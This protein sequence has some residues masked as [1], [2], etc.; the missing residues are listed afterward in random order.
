[1]VWADDVVSV[2]YQRQIL[3]D[4]FFEGRETSLHLNKPFTVIVYSVSQTKKG[5]NVESVYE[6][7]LFFSFCDVAFFSFKK[8]K[9]LQPNLFHAFIGRI[10]WL[11]LFGIRI[12]MI[13]MKF[14]KCAD[15]KRK[16]CW[17]T[18]SNGS[19]QDFSIL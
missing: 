14:I 1:M 9:E 15:G 5:Q 12:G 18:F 11:N 7:S 8:W 17:H 6:K 10:A 13:Y 2:P 4:D 3:R 19:S 16:K